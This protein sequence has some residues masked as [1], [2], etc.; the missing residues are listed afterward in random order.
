MYLIC[1]R[2]QVLDFLGPETLLYVKTHKHLQTN[3]ALTVNALIQSAVLAEMFFFCTLFCDGVR[4]PS[5]Q[6]D[7]GI[8][9]NA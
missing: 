1:E 9:P 2:I 6:N 7:M 8:C 5:E 3:G 4:F